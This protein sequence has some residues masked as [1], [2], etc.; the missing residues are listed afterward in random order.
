M[1]PQVTSDYLDH[2]G[3]RDGEQGAEQ[4]GQF[5]R[6][7]D[8]DQHGQGVEFDGAGED[9]RLQQV[10][11]QLL[12]NDEE[13]DRDDAGGHGVEEGGQRRYDRAERGAHERDQVSDADEQRDQ[14][15]KRDAEADQDRVGEPAADHADEQVPRD[16][17]GDGFGTFGAHRP[18]V[19]GPVVGE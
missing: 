5:H 3:D 17:A 9:Q 13:D 10:I 14:A 18:D 11:L 8:R 12:I 15:A 4:A 6:D 7:E 19:S 1:V 2:G 16:V